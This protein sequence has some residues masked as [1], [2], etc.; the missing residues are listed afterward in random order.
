[1]KLVDLSVDRPVTIL[2]VI[3]VIMFLLSRQ[4]ACRP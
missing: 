1:M 4:K 2:M 3:F